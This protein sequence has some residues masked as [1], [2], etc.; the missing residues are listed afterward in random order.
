MAWDPTIGQPDALESLS[1]LTTRR[2]S[3][4]ELLSRSGDTS[5]ATSSAARLG[6]LVAAE[7]P[8]IWPETLRAL[9]IHSGRWTPAMRHQFTQFSR[10]DQ[11]DRILRCFGFGVPDLSRALYSLYHQLT[12]VI[13][14]RMQPFRIQDREAKTNEMHLHRIPWPAEVLSNL[15]SAQVRMRVT[16][17]YF[18]EPKPGQRGTSRRYRY[19]SHGLR[20]EVK[21]ALE[22]DAEF[23]ARINREARDAEDATGSS[24]SDSSEWLIGPR[25]RNRGSLHSDV[26]MGSAADLAAKDAIAVF[27][28]LGWWRDA[29]RPDRCER[30]VR[31]SLVVSIESDATEIE[32]EG[33]PQS[34]DFYTEVVNLIEVTPEIEI[35]EI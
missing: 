28:V 31:Y 17:S 15:G 33:M 18:I 6:A 30:Q 13:Q 11:M 16:L 24:G 3:G 26:W 34:V 10:R 7:Y 5:G 1:L 12:L 21:T 25:L 29:R 14:E 22:S 20:F 32:I 23:L 27:P 35:I 8:D 9:L 4:S 2:R 19:A